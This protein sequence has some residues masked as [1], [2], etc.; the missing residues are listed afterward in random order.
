M[1]Q[2]A[3]HTNLEF[4]S[5]NLRVYLHGWQHLVECVQNYE[6]FQLQAVGRVAEASTGWTQLGTLLS[7]E[8]ISSEEVQEQPLVFEEQSNPAVQLRMQA[9]QLTIEAVA[10]AGRHPEE[11]EEPLES[12][13][14]TARRDDSKSTSSSRIIPAGQIVLQLSAEIHQG[15]DGARCMVSVP[16]ALLCV[17]PIHLD[18]IL[19]DITTNSNSD[20]SSSSLVFGPGDPILGLKNAEITAS[21]ETFDFIETFSGGDIPGGVGVSAMGT[22]APLRTRRSL[23]ALA[24]SLQ[25]ASVWVGQRNLCS[26]AALGQHVSY[27]MAEI[28]ALQSALASQQ[29]HHSHHHPNAGN[30][31]L[32]AADGVIHDGRGTPAAD[33]YNTS[34]ATETATPAVGTV[35]YE[36]HHTA[37]NVEVESIAIALQ[38]ERLEDSG[39]SSSANRS[40]DHGGD[41][42]S[43]AT[44]TEVSPSPLFELALSKVSIQSTDRGDG[45]SSGIA[46]LQIGFDVFNGS[47]MA[48]ESV[49]DPWGACLNFTIPRLSSNYTGS[50]SH[51]RNIGNPYASL[52]GGE[53]ERGS[54]S[55]S[56][57]A[58]GSRHLKLEVVS[59]QNFEATV[60]AAVTDAAAAAGAIISHI[61]A[62]I[63]EPD[64]LNEHILPDNSVAAA[65]S[66][67][68]TFQ[69]NNLTGADVEIWLEAPLP[70]GIIPSKPPIGPSIMCLPPSARVV[71]PVLPLYQGIAWRSRRAGK[72]SFEEGVEF[73]KSI[74]EVSSEREEENETVKTPADTAAVYTISQR[75]TLLYFR[76]SG[77]QGPL[78]G[79]V[80]LDKPG[81]VS[82][83]VHVNTPHESQVSSLLNAAAAKAA[84]TAAK[85]SPLSSS[86]PTSAAHIVVET[87][88]RRHGSFTAVLH[89]GVCISNT[90]PIDLDVGIT[91]T[92][93]AG[94]SRGSE[95][96]SSL[97]VLCSG[98]ST[99]LPATRAEMGLLHVRPTPSYRP[100]VAERYPPLS[101]RLLPPLSTRHP[102]APTPPPPSTATAVAAEGIGLSSGVQP[103]SL[104]GGPSGVVYRSGAGTSTVTPGS[105][106]HTYS[107]AGTAYGTTAFTAQY[108]SP[109]TVDCSTHGGNLFWWSAGLSLPQLIKQQCSAG[110][111]G[112][113]RE[114]SG[115]G[116]TSATVKQLSCAPISSTTSSSL[117]Y[118]GH[119]SPL[120]LTV[121]AVLQGKIHI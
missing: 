1:T 35:L 84:A 19:S 83:A 27:M 31:P 61:P 104:S 76:F 6:D 48:W 11:P 57:R 10:A 59:N 102:S 43:K 47:K 46:M 71:L 37:I 33:I 3:Q 8:E 56:S 67:P 42:T 87:A 68:V 91:Q 105:T 92:A 17:G 113:D 98:E 55:S 18:A 12:A 58:Q 97:G 13:R 34:D 62:V 69:L 79:P 118:Y 88:E 65:A 82:Y 41:T 2:R 49:I 24:V 111:G 52:R 63:L 101:A 16:S 114:G 22:T 36:E 14:T 9:K 26:A 32:G 66:L 70:G 80:Y 93:S 99:W 116:G 107:P 44:T 74:D 38:C 40:R 106:A 110:A 20:A 119:A 117:G 29:H 5:L 15:P 73:H 72:P 96:P 64:T 115:H 90:T 112:V 50:S 53:V 100:Q 103:S 120:L 39:S 21:S 25:H 4:E 60:T 75:R 54:F 81:A 77:Q 30:T 7:G 28:T 89:S 95:V 86:P 51:Y 121:G 23:D 94:S 109:S 78:S 45:G 85:S 108:G